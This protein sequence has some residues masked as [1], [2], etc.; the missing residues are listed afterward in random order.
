ME[1]IIEI[2]TIITHTHIYMRVNRNIKLHLLTS[3][4]KEILVSSWTS[5]GYSL[6]IQ[7]KNKHCT[8]FNK[9]FLYRKYFDD[10]IIG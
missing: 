10:N 3:K 4:S 5:T 9:F 8:N 6:Q 2:L 7:F 1:I